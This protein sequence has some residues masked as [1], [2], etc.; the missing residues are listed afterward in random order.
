M[1]ALMRSF[2]TRLWELDVQVCTYNR[3]YRG[4]DVVDACLLSLDTHAK[5]ESV[6]TH[7]LDFRTAHMQHV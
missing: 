6:L 4:V 2:E 3:C 5:D 7:M 1:L